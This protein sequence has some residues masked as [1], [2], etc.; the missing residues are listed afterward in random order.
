MSFYRSQQPV[1]VH[2]RRPVREGRACPR[3][4]PTHITHRGVSCTGALP[5]C[6]NRDF[7]F[8]FAGFL[9]LNSPPG[10]RKEEAK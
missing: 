2:I 7:S 3:A 4:L 9:G 6:I 5:V 8:A 1:W 10:R